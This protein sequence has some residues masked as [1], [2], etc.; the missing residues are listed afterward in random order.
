MRAEIF[1]AEPLFFENIH[2]FIFLPHQI[3]R[4]A[5]MKLHLA[6]ADRVDVGGSQATLSTGLYR[7]PC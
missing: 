7:V 2:S 6:L 1:T 5:L 4:K 3:R